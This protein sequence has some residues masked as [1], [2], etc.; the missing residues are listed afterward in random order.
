MVDQRLTRA[1]RLTHPRDIDSVF[2]GKRSDA[3]PRLV[4]YGKPNDLP[5]SRVAIVI[6]KRAGNSVVRHRFKRLVREAFRLSKPAQPLGWD[7]VVLP[8]LPSKGKP[9][10]THPSIPP[11]NEWTMPDI[12]DELI[13]LMRRQARRKLPTPTQQETNHGRRPPNT[14]S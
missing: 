2:A 12:R 9:I 5:I 1:E 10:A 4:L 14:E 11:I 3:G 13:E 8:R 7:W 6:G